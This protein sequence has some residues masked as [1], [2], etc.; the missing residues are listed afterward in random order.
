MRSISGYVPSPSDGAGTGAGAGA[1]AGT[2]VASSPPHEGIF[3]TGAGAG[4]GAGIGAGAGAGA[5]ASPDSGA[6]QA[7][8]TSRNATINKANINL[9][10]R[11]S[12]NY[13]SYIKTIEIRKGYLTLSEQNFRES[14]LTG[15][16][17]S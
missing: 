4:A 15:N 10:I 3:I 1:G 2:V 14:S 5:G 7:I 13:T 16:C 17:K 11:A 12:I 8:G 6:A 9:L